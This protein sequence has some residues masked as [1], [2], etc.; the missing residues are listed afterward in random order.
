MNKPIIL[1]HSP[2]S[3]AQLACVDL[4][5]EA[6]EEARAGNIHTVGIVVCMKT[7]YATVMAG[8]QAADLNL[9]CDSL[10]QKILDAVEHSQKTKIMRAK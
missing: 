8:T 5:S 9:G 2:L 3:E 10:K 1:P 6:L 7:G 4:L